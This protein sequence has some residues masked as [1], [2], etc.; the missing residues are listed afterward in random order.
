M[1]DTKSEKIDCDFL[2]F[3]P[4]GQS[5]KYCKKFSKRTTWGKLLFLTKFQY[6]DDDDDED[7][8]EDAADADETG[9][10]FSILR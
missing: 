6:D 5:V 1:L 8:D 2:K 9:T 3:F 10:G 7:D 4:S